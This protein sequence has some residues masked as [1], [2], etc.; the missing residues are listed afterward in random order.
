M[1]RDK[2]YANG[3]LANDKISTAQTLEADR[4]HL[5]ST[6]F[7]SLPHFLPQQLFN[8]GRGQIIMSKTWGP[9]TF[10]QLVN[11]TPFPHSQLERGL[12]SNRKLIKFISRRNSKSVT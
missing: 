3:D 5:S 2:I 10:L 1:V 7:T 4:E 12:G 6:V 8:L 11:I 9:K